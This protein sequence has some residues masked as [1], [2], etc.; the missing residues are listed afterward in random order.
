VLQD[1]MTLVI[2]DWL[3]LVRCRQTF[4]KF[5]QPLFLIGGQTKELQTIPTGAAM[6]NHSAQVKL[7]RRKR[8]PQR[9][10]LAQQNFLCQEDAHPGFRQV[11]RI[12][13]KAHVS[14]IAERD[15]NDWKVDQVSLCLTPA[16]IKNCVLTGRLGL[17]GGSWAG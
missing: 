17:F 3:F 6:S 15:D 4:D 11:L 1:K 10:N 2:E 16:T 7:D 9:H 13:L 5:R 14:G 12:A 8:E